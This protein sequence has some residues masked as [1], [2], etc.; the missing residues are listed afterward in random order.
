[1]D[2]E[3][4]KF[5]SDIDSCD[6]HLKVIGLVTVNFSL[7]ENELAF[8]IHVLL[9]LD[10]RTSQIITAELRF[11][12][13]LDLFSSLCINKMKNETAST[14]LKELVKKVYQVEQKRN[15]IIHS[16][17]AVGN[18]GDTITRFKQTAK[19][20]KGL[21]FQYEQVTVEKLQKIADEIAEATAE[22]HNFLMNNI[23]PISHGGAC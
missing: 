12:G 18:T 22:V 2:V 21:H 6:D 10:H 5:I 13:L 7:L 1:M 11:K 14:E 19:S 8:D 23:V 16:L 20:S 4:S 3:M 15:S 17:W 9:G